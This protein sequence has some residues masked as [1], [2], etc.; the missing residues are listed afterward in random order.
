M[1]TCKECKWWIS[2]PNGKQGECHESP[3][4]ESSRGK[5]GQGPIT[6]SSR[7]S[8]SLFKKKV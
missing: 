5:V 4:K 3:P 7:P 8:C 2:E 1:P 6:L